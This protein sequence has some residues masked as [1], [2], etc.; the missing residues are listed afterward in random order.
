[1][2]KAKMLRSM[3]AML[4]L[5]AAAG[6]LAAGCAGG[7]GKKQAGDG[8]DAGA[9]LAAP[10]KPENRYKITAE[11]ASF[12]RNSPQQPA[13]PD[14]QIKKETRVTLISHLAG[15]SKIQLADGGTTGFVDS[16]DIG[17][18]SPKEIA[19]E[20]AL[21]AAQHAPP[22]ALA[23]LNGGNIGNGGNYVPPSEAG[24]AEPLPVADPNPTA[25]PP[26]PAMFR[27]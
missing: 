26:P 1:M 6:L 19:D 17:H 24:R 16:A 7:A 12:F 9:D 14:Q 22:S 21:Y 25:S 4:V 11:T 18:L 8:A 23:P 10:V 20:D 5:L 13:G 27:Y 2:S 3:R 15:Y